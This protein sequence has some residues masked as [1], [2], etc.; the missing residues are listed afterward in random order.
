[1]LNAKYTAAQRLMLALAVVLVLT[2]V[3]SLVWGFGRASRLGAAYTEVL[4]QIDSLSAKQEGAK[5]GALSAEG[6]RETLYSALEDGAAV[7]GYQ[8]A[9]AGMSVLK[10]EEAFR[11]NADNLSAYMDAKED[12]AVWY[13]VKASVKGH[14]WVFN[15]TYEFSSRIMGVL[16]TCWGE[17]GELLAYVQGDYYPE[18]HM[19]HDLFRHITGLGMDYMAP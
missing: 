11:A 16:W 3:A 10:D 1:M 5:S 19:F 18:E 15:T 13:P 12:R 4:A 6:V 7:A 14:E 17:D 9:Y 8:T 2:G